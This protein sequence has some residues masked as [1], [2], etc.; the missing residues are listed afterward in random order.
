MNLRWFAYTHVMMILSMH[1]KL[2]DGLNYKS[3]DENN[4][5]KRGW[6]T[7]FSSSHFEGS[8]ARF[9]VRNNLGVEGCA[10]T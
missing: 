8:G 5:R 6:V 4:G 2:L 1:P 9:L 3:K 7:F 10:G